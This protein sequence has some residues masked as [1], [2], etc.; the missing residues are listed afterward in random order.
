MFVFY[1]LLTLYQPRFL[2]LL[3]V[4]YISDVSLQNAEPCFLALL[5]PTAA[6]SES[7][8]YLGAGN[9]EERKN[10]RVASYLQ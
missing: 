7:G 2:A 6:L 9:P 1:F 4:Q 5:H 10:S 3:Q 8:E